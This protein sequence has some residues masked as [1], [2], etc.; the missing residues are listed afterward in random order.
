MKFVSPKIWAQSK[1]N[2]TE[3]K[4]NTQKQKTRQKQIPWKPEG[5]PDIRVTDC[6]HGSLR[7][8]NKSREMPESREGET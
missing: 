7:L 6:S 2:K 4:T 5:T 8:G 3:P 1:Q